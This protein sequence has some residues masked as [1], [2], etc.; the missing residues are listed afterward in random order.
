MCDLLII[1]QREYIPESRR[2]YARATASADLP[3]EDSRWLYDNDNEDEDLAAE[4]LVKASLTRG[5]KLR[6]GEAI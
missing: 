1:C 4:L 6:F 2:V 3:D 5:K